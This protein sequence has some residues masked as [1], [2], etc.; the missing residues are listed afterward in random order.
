MNLHITLGLTA[1]AGAAVGAAAIQ[2][3]HAQAKPVAYV[4]SEITITNQDG[5]NKDYVPPVVKTI[6]DGGGKFI[7]RGGKTVSFLG[8]PPAPRVVVIQFESIDKAQAW[9]NSSANK[10]AQTI[11]DKYA[12]FHSYAVEGVSQ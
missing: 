2:S 7:A 1:V 4:V 10:D 12:T 8:A 5:Y 3:L 9:F 11:G 6:Q